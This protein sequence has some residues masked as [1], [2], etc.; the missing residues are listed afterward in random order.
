[1]G[2][3]VRVTRGKKVY[4]V[5]PPVPWDKGRAI[6]WILNRCYN[7]VQGKTLPIYV[8]DDVTDEDGFRE[9]DR[10][11]GISVLVV[12]KRR[13]SRASYYLSSPAEVAEMTERLV[14]TD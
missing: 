7:G 4:E 12:E 3:T 14:R 10:W 11:R 8:G 9:V 2:G 6:E 13:R 5:R 1:R